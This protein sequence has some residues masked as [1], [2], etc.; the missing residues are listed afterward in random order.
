MKIKASYISYNP[1][2]IYIR[3]VAISELLPYIKYVS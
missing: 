1:N 3:A 2:V